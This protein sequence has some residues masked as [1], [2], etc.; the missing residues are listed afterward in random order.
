MCWNPCVYA[1]RDCWFWFHL[2]KI[3]GSRAESSLFALWAWRLAEQEL[4]L[5]QSLLLMCTFADEPWQDLDVSRLRDVSNIFVWQDR[6][7]STVVT[8][9]SY[10]SCRARRFLDSSAQH[11]HDLCTQFV[12]GFPTI[13]DEDTDSVVE[14]FHLD[15][16][17]VTQGSEVLGLRPEHLFHVQK[18]KAHINPGHPHHDQFMRVLPPAMA[19]EQEV[20]CAQEQFS[21]PDCAADRKPRPARPAAM[22]RSYQFNRILGIDTFKVN[23]NGTWRVIL[24]LHACVRFCNNLDTLLE[25]L[26]VNRVIFPV[27]GRGA[28]YLASLPH[29]K[30][31]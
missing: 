17:S 30:E 15:D 26:F 9:H 29:C 4:Q 27:C 6:F 5:G 19:L 18:E 2:R 11:P 23:F 3:Q 7:D 20:K 22:P 21:C 24:I 1:V 8:N 14:P 31:E 16:L 10:F 13:D 28:R 25:R 12:F